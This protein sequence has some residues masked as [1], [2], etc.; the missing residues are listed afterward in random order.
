MLNGEIGWYA[1]ESNVYS[2]GE[3][4][5][6]SALVWDWQD[7]PEDFCF[8]TY[9][10][11]TVDE[12]DQSQEIDDMYFY[13]RDNGYR[14]QSFIPAYNT[15][16]RVE[17]L[18][19]RNGEPSDIT[20]YIKDDFDNDPLATFVKPASSI[21]RFNE[22][23]E[24]DIE[25]LPVNAGSTYYIIP[26]ITSGAGNNYYMWGTGIGNLYQNGDPWASTDGNNWHIFEHVTHGVVDYC[27]RT[28]GIEENYGDLEINE[29]NPIQTISN[30]L[31]VKEKRFAVKTKIIS[32]FDEE[33]IAD[34]KLS[35]NYGQNFIYD[36]GPDAGGI[37]LRAN[38]ETIVYIPGG[39]YSHDDGETW[40]DSWEET[41]PVLTQSPNNIITV[42]VDPNDEIFET[43]PDNNIE[44]INLENITDIKDFKISYYKVNNWNPSFYYDTRVHNNQFIQGIFPIS[45]LQFSGIESGEIDGS[46]LECMEG[47]NE[48]LADIAIMAWADGADKA[49]GIVSH[50]YFSDHCID[51]V[52]GIS[53]PDL[54][55]GASLL[56]EEYWIIGSHEIGHTYGLDHHESWNSGF[57]VSSRKTIIND[58]LNSNGYCFMGDQ[59]SHSINSFTS[60]DGIDFWICP[61][62]F[63]S[64]TSLLENTSQK[65]DGQKTILISGN[66]YKN[67][68]AEFNEMYVLNDKELMIPTQQSEDYSVILL[69]SVG[70]ILDDIK[71]VVEFEEDIDVLPFVFSIPFQEDISEIQ[72]IYQ[73]N[74]FC[75]RLVSSNPPENELIY[76]NGFEE[77][78]IGD[79]YEISWEANDIDGDELT[80]VVLHSTDNGM[81]W[82]TIEV[83]S[84]QNSFLWDTSNIPAGDQNIIQI[85]TS[86]GF[87]TAVDNSDNPFTL[88]NSPPDKP[89]INGPIEGDAGIEYD[90]EF[91]AIDSN[92]D[93]LFYY[94]EWGDA[95]FENWIGP[96][97]SGET[98]TISHNWSEPGTYIIRAKVK[99]ISNDES[100]WATLEIVM[101]VNHQYSFP[102]LQRLLERFPNAFPILRHL[103]EL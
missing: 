2:R 50:D 41:F 19:E 11:N 69:N 59:N 85:V 79:K 53:N 29:I 27:F 39:P 99:D 73:D 22:W 102:L 80:H 54:I 24:F 44:E 101:P 20:F 32:T 98:V 83:N 103:M 28:Y 92:L 47:I 21:S 58:P 68:T 65:G 13:I 67:N 23:V 16:T 87:N 89:I 6:Y 3:L 74:I 76:P 94:I 84:N 100:E 90:Y 26:M 96:Y 31:L 91:S 43:N 75:Q 70:I 61:N 38:G 18:L 1:A 97:E 60:S 72:M 36:D 48:D 64:L 8:K 86:D 88:L 17:L 10:T 71:F 37:P 63:E 57:W 35:Y 46:D 45:E 93:Y 34:V 4:W 78:V 49:I 81:T 52:H 25:N 14:A 42:E 55:C 56:E 51:G 7:Y 15:L 40:S 33:K 66:I 62:C 30:V 12:I 77:F 5:L 95:L 82:N 9:G